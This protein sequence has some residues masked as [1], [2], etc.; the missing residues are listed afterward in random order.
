MTSQ[1]WRLLRLLSRFGLAHEKMGF[2]TPQKTLSLP[3][4]D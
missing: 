3:K 4:R 2:S 1:A